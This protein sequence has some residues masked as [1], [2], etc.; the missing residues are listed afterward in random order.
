MTNILEFLQVGVIHE[1]IV[2]MTKD[3][4]FNTIS[5]ADDEILMEL[6]NYHAYLYEG[7]ELI[8]YENDLQTVNI[9]IEQEPRAI[10]DWGRERLKLSF[11][12]TIYEVLQAL[13]KAEII[14]E[15]YQPYCI[16]KQI[17][18]MTEGEVLL[19]FSFGAEGKMEKIQR[20][21]DASITSS[22]K[23]RLRAAQL[24]KK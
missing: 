5:D 13:D 9:K 4:V 15:F 12:T 7:V 24:K 3:D 6:P 1:V 21:I 23:S 22:L 19:F 17:A 8:F 16:Q 14:W 20:R 10:L 2:G 18:I 11:D